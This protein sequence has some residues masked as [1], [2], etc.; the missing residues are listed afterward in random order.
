MAKS[1]D[2][3][4]IRSASA[5]SAFGEV[6]GVTGTLNYQQPGVTRVEARRDA[7]GSDSPLV[8][9]AWA[10]TQVQA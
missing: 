7:G 4:V 2:G 3:A 10:P 9:A 6:L 1:A 5:G 8:G